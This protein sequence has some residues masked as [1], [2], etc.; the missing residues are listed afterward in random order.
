[1]SKTS[2]MIAA[3]GV[4]LHV[5]SSGAGGPT[6]L[7]LHFWG[8]SSRTWAPVIGL[9]S[10]EHHCI[11]VD[12]RG[13]GQS[14]KDVGPYD[15]ETLASDVLA[16][17]AALGLDDFVIVGHS[18]GGKVAQLVA[19]RR[20]TGLKQLILMAPAP[21]TPLHVPEDQ[22]RQMLESYQTPEGAETV[23]GILAAR[24]LDE[25]LHKQVVEDI[26]SGAPGAKRIWTEEGMTEDIAA[27]AGGITVPVHVIVGSEDRIEEEA[28]LKEAF[29]GVLPETSFTLIRGAGH[30]APLEATAEV[31][32]AIHSVQRARD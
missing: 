26:L 16:L 29:G 10:D 3:N 22:R 15:L 28:S 21:P 11:A 2:D 5:A 6:L 25:G 23:V 9:L 31:A 20:P 30:L 13:W 18:M 4:K 27:Q 1:M 32:L 24:A 19:A 14:E 17:V 12:F 8:G 7:F